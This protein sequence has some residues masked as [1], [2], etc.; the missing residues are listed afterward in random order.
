M[1]GAAQRDRDVAQRTIVDVQH[2]PPGDAAHVEAELVALV[3]VVVDE[4]GQQVVSQRDRGEVAGEVQVD[5]FHRHDLR[6]A[7]AGGAALHAEHRPQRRLA[8]A[9]QR[10][11]ADAVER[12]AQAHGGGG[13]AFARRRGRDRRDQHQLAVRACR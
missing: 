6:V 2:A 3:D 12:V 7:A 4:R 8:Q 9:D 11:L 5:V 1:A 13:L 10:L